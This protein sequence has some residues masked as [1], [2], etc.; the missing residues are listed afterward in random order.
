MSVNI[1]PG[2]FSPTFGTAG[3]TSAFGAARTYRDGIFIRSVFLK[4]LAIAQRL[5][6]MVIAREAGTRVP[7]V[8][9]KKGQRYTLPTKSIPAVGDVTTAFTTSGYSYPDYAAIDTFTATGDRFTQQIGAGTSVLGIPVPLQRINEGEV[10]LLINQYRGLGLAFTR[11]YL[12]ISMLENPSQYYAEM[13]KYA[14]N[15]DMERYL[16]LACLY[17]GPLTETAD[18][19]GTLFNDAIGITNKANFQLTRTLASINTGSNLITATTTGTASGMSNPTNSRFGTTPANVPWLFGSTSS[20]ISYSTITRAWE[21]FDAVNVPV[22]QRKLIMEAKGYTDVSHLPQ[23]VDTDVSGNGGGQVNYNGR[24]GKI[25]GFETF[26]TNVIQPIGA[27]S[28]VL[29]E[30]AA[31]PDA[32]AYGVQ[33]EPDL[34]IDDMLNKKEQAL[35][36]MSTSRY[37]AVVKR[38]DHIGI[39]QTRTRV[40]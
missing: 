37:G 16:W 14:M 15:N 30:L 20:D 35:V 34:I 21:K 10:E 36:L 8:T 40:G 22:G 31:G 29:Y 23:F 25:H 19:Y 38:P 1:T 17:T 18:D 11:D 9:S 7:Q 39:I 28:N 12:E 13:I 33:R 3:V 26:M 5:N 27:S 4:E 24:M 6:E 2:S 32:L